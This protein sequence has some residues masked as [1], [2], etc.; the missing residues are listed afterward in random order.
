M[1]LRIISSRILIFVGLVKMTYILAK[2]SQSLEVPIRIAEFKA[3]F[4]HF[5]AG[6]LLLFH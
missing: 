6:Y 2:L 1:P 3:K 5:L 4:K